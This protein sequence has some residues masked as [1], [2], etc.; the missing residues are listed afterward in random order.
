MVS[1]G[2]IERAVRGIL[3]KNYSAASRYQALSE[4]Q[5]INVLD[6]LDKDGSASLLHLLKASKNEV[7]SAENDKVL[8]L[9]AQHIR[10]DRKSVV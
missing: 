10:T 9:A 3:T 8:A 5:R 2:T 4:E 7:F 1:D 6:A